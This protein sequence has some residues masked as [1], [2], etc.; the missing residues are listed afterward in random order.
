MG[1]VVFF[2]QQ[3]LK[4]GGLPD[5]L[6]E[7]SPLAYGSI[8]ARLIALATTGRT[9]SPAS[10]SLGWR[11]NV[12]QAKHMKSQLLFLG[13]KVQGFKGSIAF[14]LIRSFGLRLPL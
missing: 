8:I 12:A 7:D 9:S 13:S 6:C 10:P 5:R 14:R 2:G 11:S 4:T 3:H 1:S